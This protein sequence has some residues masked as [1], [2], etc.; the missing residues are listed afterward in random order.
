MLGTLELA[1]QNLLLPY[2]GSGYARIPAA[3]K[4]PQ[5]LWTGFGS[6]LRV[7]IINTAKEAAAKEAIAAGLPGDLS[8]VACAKPLYGTTRAHYTALWR[9]W[10]AE[11]LKA[12][13]RDTRVRGLR[14]VNGNAVVKDLV[15]SG[16]RDFGL[17]D[18]DDYF[19]ARDA[20]APVSM[21]PV[22]LENGATLCLPNTVAIIRGTQ[23]ETDAQKL[24]DYLLSAE[25]ELALATGPARQIPLGPVD[26]S[27]LPPEI[28]ELKRYAADG[29]PL[30][31]LGEA[32]AACLEWLKGEYLQ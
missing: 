29:Y 2:C 30:S 11:K 15:A 7:W 18:T 10:G 27:K 3:A 4:D 31:A 21:L 22:R 28:L 32:R 19:E 14:E 12:W 13:H 9:F 5:G 8:R 17:T 24:V 25:V 1:E 20:G 6:R 23:R 26:E 16:V